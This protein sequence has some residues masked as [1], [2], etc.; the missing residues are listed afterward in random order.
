MAAGIRNR[1]SRRFHHFRQRRK[2]AGAYIQKRHQV[3]QE[4]PYL[5]TWQPQPDTAGRR[6][7]R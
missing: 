3:G 1:H 6:Q 4:F 5:H 7:N 2:K